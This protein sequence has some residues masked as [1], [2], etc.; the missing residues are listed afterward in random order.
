MYVTLII[1]YQKFIL[2]A[3]KCYIISFLLYIWHRQYVP[4][5]Q[6]AHE[7]LMKIILIHEQFF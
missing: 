6:V 2:T 4:P 7:N 1:L 5:K 3:V